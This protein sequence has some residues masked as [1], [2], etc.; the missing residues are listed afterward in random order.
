MIGLDR[1]G[2]RW[3]LCTKRQLDDRHQASG[4]AD[5]DK[6]GRLMDQVLVNAPPERVE[7]KAFLVF[8]E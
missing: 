1:E 3:R 4:T 8:S 2:Q 7:L 6:A 5:N